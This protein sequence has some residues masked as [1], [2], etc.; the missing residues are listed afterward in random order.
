MQILD[1][2]FEEDEADLDHADIY[3][4]SPSL[5]DS[6]LGFVL[7]D[8]TSSPFDSPNTIPWAVPS[9]ICP[10]KTSFACQVCGSNLASEKALLDHQATVHRVS[11]DRRNQEP[12]RCRRCKIEFAVNYYYYQHM[13][14]IHQLFACEMCDDIFDSEARLT[15]HLKNCSEMEASSRD[16]DSFLATSG[17]IR[18]TI[19][20]LRH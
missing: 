6:Q 12:K 4:T 16:C 3:A 14:Q 10:T 11:L 5:H 9:A 1:D 8:T 20:L 7:S 19:E 13:K 18:K 17:N 15:A 2:E